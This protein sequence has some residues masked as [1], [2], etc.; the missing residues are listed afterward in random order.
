MILINQILDKVSK[1]VQIALFI[2]VVVF[3]TTHYFI[4]KEEHKKEATIAVGQV[5]LYNDD[6]NNPFNLENPRHRTVLDI[7]GD[8]VLYVN[9]FKDTLSVSKGVFIR[10]SVRVK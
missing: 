6:A 2:A 1:V 10:N 5:W 9:V 8:Y 4:I 7:K 3:L